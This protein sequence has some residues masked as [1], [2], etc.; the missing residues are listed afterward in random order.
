MRK[1]IELK[2]YYKDH[3]QAHSTALALGGQHVDSQVEVDTYFWTPT[4]RLKFRERDRSPSS[5]IFYQRLDSPT[6]RASD[7]EIL[8]LEVN[9]PKVRDFLSKALGVRAVV[10]KTRDTYQLGN[11][12]VHLDQLQQVGT[13]LEI[14]V[15]VPEGHSDEQASAV[16]DSLRRRFGVPQAHIVPW[17]YAELVVIYEASLRWRS[18]LHNVNRQGILFLLDGASGSGKTTLA[19]RIMSD[20][21]LGLTYVPRYTTRPPRTAT[22]EEYIFVSTRDFTDLAHRGHFLEYR[23]F[24]FDMSYGVPWREAVTPLTHGSSALGIMNLGNVFHVKRIF[25]EAVLILITAS[26]QAI[27]QRL[28]ERGVHTESQIVERLQNARSTAE[29]RQYYDHVVVNENHALD[30]AA[31]TLGQIIRSHQTRECT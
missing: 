2:A 7:F 20:P 19:H 28:L 5:L 17:S 22:D 6:I 16:A 10:K 15:T 29:L 25:P 12:L 18:L 9:A 30:N 11:A 8:P 23:D 21:S 3:D 14:E 31:H 13:F 24:K 26:E 4:G 1:N 27:R